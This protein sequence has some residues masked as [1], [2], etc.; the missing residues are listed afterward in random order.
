MSIQQRSK[1]G[2]KASIARTHKKMAR[3]FR[4][5]GHYL[6]VPAGLFSVAPAVPSVLTCTKK[7][8]GL[9]TQPLHSVPSDRDRHGLRCRADRGRMEAL[10]IRMSETTRD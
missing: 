9:V 10:R 3:H 4:A 7:V 8:G 5:L 2:A 1:N 6:C